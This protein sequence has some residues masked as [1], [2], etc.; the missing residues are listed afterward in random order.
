MFA[1]ENSVRHSAHEHPRGVGDVCGSQ[2]VFGEQVVVVCRLAESVADAD[3]FHRRRPLFAENFGYG[4]AQTAD[5]GVVFGGY[6]FAGGLGSGDD[7]VLVE[8]LDGR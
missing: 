3:A 4:T 1:S 7:G 5:H 8:W 6:N 2:S